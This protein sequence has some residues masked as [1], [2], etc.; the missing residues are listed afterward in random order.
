MKNYRQAKN[1]KRRKVG[2]NLTS[3]SK[4]RKDAFDIT[5]VLS[6]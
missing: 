5:K 1:A 6:Y 3:L 4:S 2:W